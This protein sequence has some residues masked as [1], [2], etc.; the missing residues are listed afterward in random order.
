MQ[1]RANGVTGPL[2]AT[3]R[4]NAVAGFEP[5][6]AHVIIRPQ[7]IT[8]LDAK[9][10]QWRKRHAVQSVPKLMGNGPHGLLGAHV[11]PIVNNFAVATAIILNPITVGVIAKAKIL[12]VRIALEAC[13]NVSGVLFKYL[14]I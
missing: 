8:G 10:R 3:V 14:S 2:G 11:V 5:V 6:P 7:L 4:P 12:P 1:Y 9:A 13:V